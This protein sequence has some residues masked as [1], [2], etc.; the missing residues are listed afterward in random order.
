MSRKKG[1]I[2]IVACLRDFN[3]GRDPGRLA[4]KYRN[5]RADAFVFLRGTCHLYFDRVSQSG[6]LLDEAPN[7][8]VCGD[9]HFENFGSY[10]GDNGLTYFDINDFDEATLAPLSWDVG[11]FLSSLQVASKALRTTPAQTE[12]L[13]TLFLDSYTAALASGRIGWLERETATGLIG[14]LLQQLES[15]RRSDFLDQHTWFKG[16]QRRIICDGKHAIAVSDDQRRKARELVETSAAA[17]EKPDFFTVLDVVNRIA[18][19]GSLGLERFAVLVQGKGSPDRNALL[20]LKQVVGSSL[21]RHLGRP[22]PNWPS[23][24]ARII[25]L[26]QRMQCVP[27]RFLEAI[28]DGAT[29]YVLR[30]LQPVEDRVALGAARLSMRQMQGIII[31]MARLTAWAHLRG[32]G[33]GGSAIADELI[34][35]AGDHARW[36][37]KLLAA[38]TAAA[39]QVNR[40]WATYAA[41]YDA[42]AFALDQ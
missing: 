16:K 36:R 24:A 9:L 32:S 17:K 33:R 1:G 41:A 38:A 15:R 42:G 14:E 35:F 39:D 11:R 22:V 10:K 18:G 21:Q 40:D 28:P 4:L 2:D 5:M 29:S 20:D 37:E 25:A 34:A 23:E 30:A 26:R 27:P 6:G 13:C 8:W 31:E 3:R 19:T 7:A 12:A